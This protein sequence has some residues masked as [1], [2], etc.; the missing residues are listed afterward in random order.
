MASVQVIADRLDSSLTR[1]LSKAEAAQRL[2]TF[3]RNVF[4]RRE[5]RLLRALLRH[6]SGLLTLL[7]LAAVVISLTLGEIADAIIIGA[8][9]L[10]NLFLGLTYESVAHYR[11]DRIRSRIP[12]IAEVVR[13]GARVLAA[14]EELVPGDLVTLRAGERI[15]ADL[16]LATSRGLRVD[17][18]VLTGEPGDVEKNPATLAGPAQLVDQRNMVFAGTVITTGS[19]EG[20]VT[21]TGAR[22][23]LGRLAQRVVSAG[24]QVTPLEARLRKLEQGIGVGLLLTAS[25]LF[26]V[27]VLRG[28]TPTGMFRSAL[29]LTVAAIPESLTLILTVTL[30]VGAT[31]LLRR[32]AIVRHLTAAETLGDCTVAAIDKTGTLT[33]GQLTLRRIEGIADQWGVSAFRHPQK[34]SLL[35]QVFIAATAS[36]DR[37]TGDTPRGPAI[38]RALVAAARDAGIR[39]DEIRHFYRLL[40][41]L[42]FDARARYAAS[43]HDDPTRPESVA[44]TVGAP[45]V[46]LPRCTR[47]TDGETE[48]SF[49]P[50]ARTTWLD[51]TATVAAE[52]TR[53]VAVCRRTLPRTTRTL[54]H[55]DIR[56][57]TFLALLHIDDPLRPDAKEA[58]GGLRTAGVRPILLTGDHQGTA[59]AVARAT[60]ILRPGSITIDGQTVTQL[61]DRALEDVLAT[62]DVITRV[63][64]FAK[65]RIVQAL[66]RRGEIVAM[67]GDGVNDAVALRRADIGVAVTTATDVA[68]DASDLVLVNT[69]LATLTAAVREG[70]RIRETVRTVLAFLFSTNLGEV[71]AVGAALAAGMP[72]P[73][74][75]AHLLW[76]NIVTD[77][78]ATVA[79]ALEPEGTRAGDARPHHTRGLF[80]SA[81][82]LGMLVTAVAVVVPAFVLYTATLGRGAPLAYAQTLAFVTLALGQ[83]VAAFSFRSLTRP[84]VRLSPLSNV[85]LLASTVGS[86]ALLVAGVHWPPIANLLRTVPLSGTDWITVVVG[87]LVGLIG[88]EARKPLVRLLTSASSPRTWTPLT[89]RAATRPLAT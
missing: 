64:P 72:L 84:L 47:V 13:G 34:H 5:R 54:S 9:L 71:L 75:P 30:A 52:G 62:T 22:S 40:A 43:L 16:R 45:E 73:F 67:L 39:D 56:D 14:A 21:A 41:S 33:T 17:E 57:L 77:G 48:Q 36:I 25:G 20:I 55:R 69:G 44:F 27:G 74:L 15:P 26:A 70:R 50:A 38:D 10:L 4:D 35:H 58:V 83:I 8:V 81:D 87:A 59:E 24:W 29:T 88:V 7:L 46:L 11:L 80:R 37:G 53:V 68:K 65:E 61:P 42:S 31:R 3:G 85:W 79:L 89:A 76:I 86:V 78:T 6:L 49:S 1:G 51:R 63:D 32:G 82:V 28:E 66:Q 2:T 23:T 12:R 18:S 60:T 19:A